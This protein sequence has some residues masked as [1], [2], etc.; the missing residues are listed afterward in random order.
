LLGALADAPALPAVLLAASTS[1]AHADALRAQGYRT[2]YAASD[3]LKHEAKQMG[4]RFI[5]Q[6]PKLEDLS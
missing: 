4:C 2:C 5:Y 1:E 3:N 6:H